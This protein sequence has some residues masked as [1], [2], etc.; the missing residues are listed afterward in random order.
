LPIAVADKGRNST[1]DAFLRR[2][3]GATLTMPHRPGLVGQVQASVALAAT[4]NK[5]SIFYTEPDKESFF[6]DGMHSFLRRVP[7]EVDVGVA[8]PS[9]S[10]SSFASFPPMRRN[11]E[12]VIKHLWAQCMDV[13]GDYSDGPLLI[14]RTLLPHIAVL[15]THLGW[16]W[17][18]STCLAAH[19][20]ALRIIHVEGDHPC[21]PDQRGED[22]TDRIHRMRQSSQSILG[23]IECE[24]ADEYR[25]E[26]LKVGTT[27]IP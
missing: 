27:I 15:P 2:L 22:E 13:A 11:T 19:R 26:R 10:D 3:R 1:F 20:A 25:F 23:L 7:H 16:G 8:M 21:P 5:D 4:F 9:R 12:G 14:T 24:V 18:S 6:A 17:R